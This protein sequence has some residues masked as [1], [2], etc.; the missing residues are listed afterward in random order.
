MRLKNMLMF[1]VRSQ[2]PNSQKVMFPDTIEYG[3]SITL[4]SK[5]IIDSIAVTAK[6]TK[7]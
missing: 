3:G 2:I 6:F 5:V 1:T 4:G 7:V